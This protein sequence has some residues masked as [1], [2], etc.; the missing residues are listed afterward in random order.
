MSAMAVEKPLV[1]DM[2]CFYHSEIMSDHCI[3]TKNCKLQYHGLTQVIQAVQ[4]ASFG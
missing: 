1:A 4:F 2:G 3:I